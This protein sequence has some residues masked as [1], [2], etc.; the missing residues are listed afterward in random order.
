MHDRQAELSI[1]P[2]RSIFNNAF[3]ETDSVSERIQ[4]IPQILWELDAQFPSALDY[5]GSIKGDLCCILP[6]MFEENGFYYLYISIS[7]PDHPLIP[8]G[9][10]NAG[11]QPLLS[12]LPLLQ[13][14]IGCETDLF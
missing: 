10:A 13:W 11:L 5:V 2:F 9:R 6:V 4:D 8:F 12:I 14:Q 7:F 1:R 3:R